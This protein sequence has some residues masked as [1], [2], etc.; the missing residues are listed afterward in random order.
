V[1]LFQR[2]AASIGPLPLRTTQRSGILAKPGEATSAAF[3][4]SGGLME[5]LSARGHSERDQRWS[6]RLWLARLVMT[7]GIALVTAGLYVAVAGNEIVASSGPV[8]RTVETWSI[9][10]TG[11]TVYALLH[12]PRSVP[13]LLVFDALYSVVTLGGLALLLF[14]WRP[15]SPAATMR[16]RWTSGLWLVLLTTLAVAGE[17]ARWQHVTQ[18]ASGTASSLISVEPPDLL[19]GLIVFPLGV[20]LCSA[21]LFL[22]WEPLPTTT[23]PPARRAGWQ[24]A[25]ALLLT[26]G[27]ALWG[28]GFYLMPQAVTDAC[29]PVIFSVTQFAHGACAGIDSDQ[30]LQAAAYAG[31]HPIALVFY[32]V[33]GSFEL[34]VALGC[35]TVLSGWIRPPSFTSLAFPAVWFALALGV[36]LV[37]AYG[38]AVAARQGFLLTATSVSWHAASGIIATFVG[39]ALVVLAQVVVWGELLNRNR[40]QEA[41][42][43]LGGIRWRFTSC[44]RWFVVRNEQG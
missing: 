21:A 11:I 20:A 15:L 3:F 5:I 19:P 12:L 16:L 25:S 33:S 30:V 31:L 26:V 6:R 42:R 41:P 10:D 13:L 8:I 39:I 35:L 38:V 14:L 4:L 27:V 9:H 7:V 17:V 43:H 36:A 24:W 32:M 28:V 37:A 22:R 1:E 40:Q 34:L 23:T 2:A 18:R 29:P 44:M